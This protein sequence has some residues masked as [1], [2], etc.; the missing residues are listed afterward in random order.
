MKKNEIKVGQTFQDAYDFAV[1]W[2]VTNVYDDMVELKWSD[3]C[4]KTWQPTFK[5]CRNDLCVYVDQKSWEIL[6]N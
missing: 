1:V 6:S 4:G 5:M 3:N 2:V